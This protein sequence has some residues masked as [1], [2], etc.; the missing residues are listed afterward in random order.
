MRNCVILEKNQSC[1]RF[2]SAFEP[3]GEGHNATFFSVPGAF[4]A[5]SM[6]DDPFLYV[7]ERRDADHF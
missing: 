2:T 7:D 1:I 4:P 6:E 3:S 5:H